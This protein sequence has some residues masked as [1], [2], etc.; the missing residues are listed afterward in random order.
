MGYFLC[1]SFTALDVLMQRDQAV[2]FMVMGLWEPEHNVVV[3]DETLLKDIS[4]F[5]KCAPDV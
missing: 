1:K 4:G 5:S 2:G 3:L